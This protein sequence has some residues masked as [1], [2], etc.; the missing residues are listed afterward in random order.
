MAYCKPELKAKAI[1]H[2]LV[3]SHPNRKHVRQK[4]AYPVSAI[5]LIQTHF[6]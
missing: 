5:G 3:S 4:L 6:Y 2:L 1:E